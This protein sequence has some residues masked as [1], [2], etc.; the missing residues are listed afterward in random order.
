[1]ISTDLSD[2]AVTLDGLVVEHGDGEGG[3]VEV[4]DAR[5]HAEYEL[6]VEAGVRRFLPAAGHLPR[7]GSTGLRQFHPHVRVYNTRHTM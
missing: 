5:G 3:V 4:G 6:L 1:M 2:D 7:D